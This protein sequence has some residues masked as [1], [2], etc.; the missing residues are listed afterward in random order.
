MKNKFKFIGIIAL[1]VVIVV[2]MA[3]CDNGTTG[4]GSN[5]DPKTI[6]IT[7]VPPSW[8]GTIAVYIFSEFKTSGVPDY[9][10]GKSYAFS[11][12]VT[13]A[14]LSPFTESGEYYITIQTSNSTRDGYVLFWQR[15]L[16]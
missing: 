5:S 6:K 9:V 10:A 14:D 16:A 11:G 4:G 7:D 13:N 15:K 8:A 3:A 12:G 1:F 2:S